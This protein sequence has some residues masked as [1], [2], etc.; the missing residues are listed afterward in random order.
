MLR[1]TQISFFVDP[2]G[3]PPEQLLHDWRSLVDIA[4][5]P[6]SGG[7]RVTVVQ[8]CR[9][10]RTIERDGVTFHFVKP[11]RSGLVQS[12]AFTHYRSPE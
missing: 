9:H 4:A 5:A 6:A 11:G 1:V 3:R 2:E 12:D 7:A 10:A 8:A